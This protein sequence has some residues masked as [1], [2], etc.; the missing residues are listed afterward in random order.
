MNFIKQNMLQQVDQNYL[1]FLSFTWLIIINIIYVLIKCNVLKF[2]GYINAFGYREL[3]KLNF[4]YFKPFKI[5]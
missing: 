3:S 5:Y 1:I 4:N 2:I